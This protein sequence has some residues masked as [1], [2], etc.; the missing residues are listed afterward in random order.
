[1]SKLTD[2]VH[3]LV[4]PLAEE[5]GLELLEVQYKQEQKKW[6]LRL[7]IDKRGGIS[8]D[9]CERLS[10]K[11]DPVIDE[12]VDIRQSYYLEVQSPG[13]DRPLKT[14]ADFARYVGT[15]VELTF[16]QKLDGKKKIQGTL[17]AHDKDSLTLDVNGT[18]QA[19]DLP[20]VA[21]VKRVINFG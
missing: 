11:A 15:D 18:E 17:L 12:N 13:L 7:I 10:R 20:A 2:Q 5:E 8:I 14:Q 6:Y 16:Y 4:A 3:D 21:Q 1:M 9:D 19:F